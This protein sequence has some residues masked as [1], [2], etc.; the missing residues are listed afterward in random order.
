MLMRNAASCRLELA[1]APLPSGIGMEIVRG[2]PLAAFGRNKL[3]ELRKE[4]E[5]IL[6]Q[7]DV[8]LFELHA[9][10]GQRLKARPAPGNTDKAALNEP[11]MA[12]IGQPVFARHVMHD[13]GAGKG[14]GGLVLLEQPVALSGKLGQRFGAEA[15]PVSG[16]EVI[17]GEIDGYAGKAA[18]LRRE[19]L[20]AARGDRVLISEA[21]DLSVQFDA[22]QQ[23][24][25]IGQVF[26]P[27]FDEVAEK[28]ADQ[29]VLSSGTKQ[30]MGQIIQAG[31]R[32]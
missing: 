8:V 9:A 26:E 4:S 14:E 28:T 25:F 20:A 29:A 5:E 12:V 18:A 17:V 30:K 15:A 6:L 1:S 11:E 24:A 22:A 23:F 2:Q 16:Q 32:S 3:Q 7:V 10:V 27:A 19:A 21:V 31:S 13:T